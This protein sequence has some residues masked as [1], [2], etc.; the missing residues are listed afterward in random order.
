[1]I[2]RSVILM[3]SFLS[4]KMLQQLLVCVSGVSAAERDKMKGTSVKEGESGIVNIVY[5][6]IVKTC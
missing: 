1:M 3:Q 5:P 6:G 2:S 4:R